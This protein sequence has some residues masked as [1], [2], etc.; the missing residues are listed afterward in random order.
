MKRDRSEVA[1]EAV[2]LL[3]HEVD[4]RGHDAR[5]D[6]HGADEVRQALVGERAEVDHHAACALHPHTHRL[7]DPIE[8]RVQRRDALGGRARAQR[9]RE[10]EEADLARL[11]LNEQVEARVRFDLVCEQRGVGHGE[12]HAVA[13]ALGPVPLPGE[14]ELEAVGLAAALQAFLP[15]VA[16]GVGGLVEEVV[17]NGAVAALERPDVAVDQHDGALHRD[18]EQLVRVEAEGVSPFRA[19]QQPAVLL[20][21]E[22]RAA[23]RAVDM[24]PH[25]VPLANGLDL[26]Q[27][28]EGAGH[29]GS[30]SAAHKERC[31]SRRSCN[32]QRF[33]ELL[34][35]HGSGSIGSNFNHRLGSHAC[36]HRGFLDRVV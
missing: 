29:S 28:V 19:V 17:R 22:H 27:G 35:D 14:P 26:A 21:H 9:R 24:H 12:V 3:K 15:E 4:V 5:L 7:R 11:R 33:L 36:D 13:E 16:L 8:L 2:D 20:G 34:R 31:L 18:A 25:A 1:S 10:V 30:G 32:R 6:H 23:P